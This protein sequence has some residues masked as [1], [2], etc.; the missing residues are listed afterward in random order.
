ME[1]FVFAAP[2]PGPVEIGTLGWLS[3]VAQ[4]VALMPLWL[5]ARQALGF[6]AAEREPRQLRLI[7]GGRELDRR[8]A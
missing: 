1:W 7:E 3:V 5:V 4:A 2:V 8:A 6:G